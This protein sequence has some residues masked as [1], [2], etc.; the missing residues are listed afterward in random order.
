MPLK[1][2]ISME[3]LLEKKFDLLPLS[4]RWREFLGAPECTGSWFVYGESGHG[5]TSFLMLLAKE[6]ARYRRVAY[7]TLEEGAR[8]SM[9]DLVSEN[10]M[11]EVSSRFVV[12]DRESMEDLDKRLQ[13]QR[14]PG[15]VIIDS[16]QYA[17]LTK[18]SYKSLVSNHPKKL[19]IFSSH[20]NGKDP[21]GAIGRDILFDADIKIRVE[22][23]KAFATS[24][25]KRGIVPTPFVIWPQGAKDY[26]DR[27]KEEK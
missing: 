17:F 14:S 20:A 5:K 7:N 23:F 24:R 19:F 15:V 3:T 25:V 2:A 10:N 6:L 4:K 11:K 8:K 18:R 22:G 12:L 16:A 13:R 1:K 27:K 26:W 9:Q 21:V